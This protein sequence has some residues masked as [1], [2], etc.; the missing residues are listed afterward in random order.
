MIYYLIIAAFTAFLLLLV[1]ALAPDTTVIDVLIGI[2]FWSLL[3][4]ILVLMYWKFSD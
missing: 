1:A 2:P 4:P 3:W